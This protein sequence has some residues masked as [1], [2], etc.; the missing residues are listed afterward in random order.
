MSPQ[1]RLP[2]SCGQFV[3]V[4]VAQ[5]GA[6]TRCACGATLEIPGSRAITQLQPESSEGSRAA[7]PQST[8][9]V[10]R[11]LFAMLF[12]I[13]LLSGLSIAYYGLLVS[14]IP[15]GKSFESIGDMADQRIDEMS[16][17]ELLDFHRSVIQ[18]GLTKSPLPEQ[19]ELY[20]LRGQL[21]QKLKRNGTIAGIAFALAMLVGWFTRNKNAATG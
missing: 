13:A 18:Q 9:A 1:Y 3:L 11:I 6:K 19:V 17:P 14:S 10:A 5:A 2:C 12:A 16:L 15:A 20:R 4:Q 7:A 8:H 21:L